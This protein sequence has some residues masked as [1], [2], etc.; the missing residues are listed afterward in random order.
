VESLSPAG[1]LYLETLSE[2]RGC[3]RSGTQM[4]EMSQPVSD[5]DS[6]GQPLPHRWAA[7]CSTGEA[8]F[9]DDMSPAQGMAGD[10]FFF[11]K[12]HTQGTHKNKGKKLSGAEELHKNLTSHL[13]KWEK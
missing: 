4:Y 11:Y 9:I 6:V 2:R 8:V 3:T 13:E 12:T 7:Q 1:E 5:T 10:I